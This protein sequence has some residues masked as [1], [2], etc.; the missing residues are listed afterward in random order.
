VSNPVLIGH[1]SEPAVDVCESTLL[2]R[3]DDTGSAMASCD[4]GKEKG[5]EEILR[6]GAVR[7]YSSDAG[8]VILFGNGR[9]V[10]STSMLAFP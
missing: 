10:R 8:C 7:K 6:V 4:D 5:I 1:V 2:R 9:A 3:L